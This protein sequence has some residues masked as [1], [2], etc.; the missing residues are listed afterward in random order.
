LKYFETPIP[1]PDWQ[2][3]A[4]PEQAE[5]AE[6]VSARKIVVTTE[7]LGATRLL[8]EPRWDESACLHKA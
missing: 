6:T 2:P 7:Y 3:Y 5:E 1:V 8:R 4:H